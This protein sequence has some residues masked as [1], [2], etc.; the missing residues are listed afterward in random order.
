MRKECADVTIDAYSFG[1]I[2]IN[3]REYDSDVL[4][5]P[6]GRIDAAWWRNEGHVL[7]ESDIADLIRS[8]PETII[9]GTGEIRYK[10]ME[11]TR[12]LQRCWPLELLYMG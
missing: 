11:K 6:D 7:A 3:G 1:R 4:I 8:Q 2:V 5:Y 9:A 10:M 12:E